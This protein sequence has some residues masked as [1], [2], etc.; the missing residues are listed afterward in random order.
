M[1]KCVVIL[2]PNSGKNKKK[3]IVN[4]YKN[5]LL[6]HKYEPTFKYTSYAGHA[7]K[8]VSE[9]SE[10]IDLVISL[11]GDGTFNEVMSGNFQR[12]NRLLLTHIPYGTT[13]DIGAMYGMGKDPIAN[14][15]AVLNGTVKKLD[16]CLINNQPFVYVA[17]LG[18]F[19]NIAYDTPRKM[20]KKLGYLAYLINGIKSFN[21]KTKL[22]EMTYEVNGEKVTGLFSLIL[23]GNAS[24]IAGL[25]F[26]QDVK[27]DDDQFEVLLSNFKTKTDLAKGLYYFKLN[28]INKA[29]GFSYFKTNHLKIKLKE[30]P[31]Q[32]WCLDGEEYKFNTKEFDITIDKNVHMLLPNKELD[33]LFINKG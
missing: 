4:D 22:F 32:S 21:S 1:K 17:G 26:F 24:R 3:D 29:P 19:V 13:N 9:L 25:N 6:K 28:D 8:I 10:D 33:K 23:I 14:L 18:K 2:N 11:G 5:I 15:K 30:T 12:K 31:K 7:K 27:L 20:K 16:M